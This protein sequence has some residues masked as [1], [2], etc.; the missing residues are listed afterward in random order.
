MLPQRLIED[1]PDRAEVVEDFLRWLREAE[2]TEDLYSQPD[3]DYRIVEELADRPRQCCG[4][5]ITAGKEDRHDLVADEFR[6][7]GMTCDAAQEREAVADLDGSST[8]LSGRARARATMG[9]INCS[10]F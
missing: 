9:S 1:A 7:L 5:N 4:S 6:I 2:S 3:L 8:P 10:I